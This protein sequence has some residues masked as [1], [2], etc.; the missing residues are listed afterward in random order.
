MRTRTLAWWR[1]GHPWPATAARWGLAAGAGVVVALATAAPA[2][3]HGADAPDGTDYRTAVT[4][5]TPAVAGITVRAV[6]AGGRLE[7][8]NGTGRT[9][10]VLGYQGEPY[11][12][13]RPDGVYE[14][15]HSPATYLNVTIA[16]DAAVPA[17]ADPTVAPQWRKVSDR[18]VARWHDRR[19]HWTD[20]SPPSQVAADPRRDH[21]VRD[22]TVPLRDAGNPVAVRGTLDWVAPPV[23]QLWWAAAGLL[24]VAVAALGLL[25]PEHRV[26]VPVLGS[27]AVGGGAVAIGYAVAREV[28]AGA[29]GPA[30]VALGLLLGQLWPVLTALATVLAGGYALARRP[31]ADFAVTL[32]GAGLAAFAGLPNLVVFHRAVAPVPWPA[33][34]ARVL[35]AVVLGVGVGLAV[36][37]ALRLRAASYA[38]ARSAGTAPSPLD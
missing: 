29:T 3:A 19:T 17:T 4:A 9:V 36:A 5:V 35:V 20:G 23:A 24:A 27:L 11:L 21:R 28:D 37:G 6:E 22:W 38:A 26:V 34:G 18:P 2:S 33:A 1:T 16:G 7:L 12:E 25:P 30:A 15:V 8:H 31:A 10:E 13:V 14:N 32:A